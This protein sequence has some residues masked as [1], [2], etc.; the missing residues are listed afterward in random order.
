MK[1]SILPA[2][3]FLLA[4]APTAMA[5]T[6]PADLARKNGCM[7]CHGLLHRQVGPGFAQISDRYRSDIEAPARLTGKIR[8]GSVG[9]WGRV[10]M[11]RQAHVSEADARALAEWV[12][13]QPPPNAGSK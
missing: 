10:I 7:S 6:L 9:T 3:A 2:A 12:L 11:P 8:N 1:F 13:S 5:Q 4:A